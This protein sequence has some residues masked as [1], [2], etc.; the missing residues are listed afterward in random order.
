MKRKAFLNSAHWNGPASVKAKVNFQSTWR[1]SSEVIQGHAKTGATHSRSAE[2]T[3]TANSLCILATTPFGF[4]LWRVTNP[5][6]CAGAHHTLHLLCWMPTANCT[7]HVSLASFGSLPVVAPS[8]R[9]KQST[10]CNLRCRTQ[11]FQQF[12][13]GQSLAQPTV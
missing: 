2:L 1:T 8:I 5:W 7:K 12:W 3:C 13:K 10:A 11:I 9:K 6:F 4:V